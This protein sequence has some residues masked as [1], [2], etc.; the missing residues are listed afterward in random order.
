MLKVLAHPV[1]IRIVELLMQGE[2]SVGELAEKISASP[3]AVSQHLN[4]M[5]AH[6]IVAGKR[7]DRKVYYRVVNVN[8]SNL[9]DCLKRHGDGRR[10]QDRKK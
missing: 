6:D 8:A 1:R 2:F 4:R 10:R 7:T 9:I 3:A 5:A